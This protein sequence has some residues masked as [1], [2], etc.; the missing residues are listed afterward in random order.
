MRAARWTP[1]GSIL[2]TP[3]FCDERIHMYLARELEEGLAAP[4]EHEL[5]EVHWVALSEALEWVRNGRIE[6]AKTLVALFRAAA[7]LGRGE[8]KR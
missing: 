5:L 4:G 2:T 6:D 7:L 1:L 8:G 3:G